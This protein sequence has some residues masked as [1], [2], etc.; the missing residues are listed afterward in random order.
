MCNED[1]TDVDYVLFDGHSTARFGAL[2]EINASNHARYTCKVSSITYDGFYNYIC[3]RLGFSIAIVSEY[4]H[5]RTGLL[6]LGMGGGGQRPTP[7]RS[8]SCVQKH[9]DIELGGIN[10]I[11][12]WVYRKVS[13]FDK[14]ISRFSAKFFFNILLKFE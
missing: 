6:L 8:N 5:R 14:F 9:Q 12:H 4:R 10:A 2:V 11:I 13:D 7:P 3:N 1:E